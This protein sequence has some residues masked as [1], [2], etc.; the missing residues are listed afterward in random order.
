M[1]IRK[2]FTVNPNRTKEEI[3]DYER[4]LKENKY[5]GVEIF[6]PYRKTQEEIETYK[7]AIMTYLKYNPEMVC[8]LPYGADSNLATYENLEEVMS[9]M[10]KAMD[11]ASLFGV[12]KLTLHP[13]SCDGTLE[14]A[15]AINLCAKNVKELCKYADQYGMTVMLENLIGTQELMRTP[16]EYFEIK[17][18]VNEP[19][20]KFIFDVA[21][22]HASQ[23]DNGDVQGILDF[24]EKVKNDLYHLHISDNDG[25]RDMHARIGVGNIDFVSYFKKL[26]EVGYTG[27]FSS[28]V[29]YNDSAD[30]EM[31]A[32]DMEK[33][34]A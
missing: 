17:E 6:Y 13:G 21:H 7:N 29:L 9:R 23:F 32:N 11:F 5:V 8:H 25:N 28:E 27:L 4:M 18:K 33:Q 16:E 10:K 2:C 26:D 31:T 14:R 24:V 30:L 12:K 20:L 1:I 19:N 15:D 22:F 3:A 34:K